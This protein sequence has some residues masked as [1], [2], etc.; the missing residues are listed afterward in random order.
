MEDI[1]IL[2]VE[3]DKDISNMIKKALN[4]EGYGVS[5]AF[6]GQEALNVWDK[7][8][9]KLFIL[10]IMLPQIDGIEV[11]RRIRMKSMVPILMV[12]A[13]AEESDRII[14][15]GLGADDYLVK[16]FAIAELIARVK[17]LL[18]RYMYYSSREDIMGN[19]I[20]YGEI[21]FDLD[22]YTAIKKDKTINL[23]AKEYELLKLFFKNPNKV[24]TKAQIFSSVW[25]EEYLGDDNTVMVHIRRL[26][27][28]IEDNPDKPK[29]IETVWGIGYRLGSLK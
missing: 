11:M 29:Y 10:D 17:A 22:N 28:K 13:K 5:C 27:N 3:D 20:E 1:K 2:I 18:R 25:R 14:G 4:K 12:S 8:N 15:L 9:C 26:R 6:D 19:T 21:K 16:P 23:R 7:E 24:F